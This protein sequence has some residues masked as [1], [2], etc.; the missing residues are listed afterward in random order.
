M[1]IANFAETV[2]HW[3]TFHITRSLQVIVIRYSKQLCPENLDLAIYT[4]VG[5]TSML[6]KHFS[7]LVQIWPGRLLSS[8]PNVARLFIRSVSHKSTKDF[9]CQVEVRMF[10]ETM[11]EYQRLVKAVQR[12]KNRAKVSKVKE[13]LKSKQNIHYIMETMEPMQSF[14]EV[15]DFCRKKLE[16]T[17]NVL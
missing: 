5:N 11:N 14:A 10:N 2:Y 8:Y 16:C 17:S 12:V 7:H 6:L 4:E 1:Y 9:K 13:I 15:D 3:I